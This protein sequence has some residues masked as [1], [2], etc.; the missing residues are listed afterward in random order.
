IL[1]VKERLQQAK[2]EDQVVL[3]F[4]GHGL[5]DKKLDYYF[6][7]VDIDFREPA[8]RGL[9]YEEIEGLL[10]GIKARKKLLLI[11]TCHSGEL[12]K[13]D[14][15]IVEMSGKPLG[16]GV[17]AWAA[18]GDLELL[19]KLKSSVKVSHQVLQ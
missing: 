6:C 17:R 7:T 9:L 18:R 13:E 10:D 11:D 2:V 19:P 15:A 8:R 14:L 1:K 16:R 5:L 3:F 4:A 12:D